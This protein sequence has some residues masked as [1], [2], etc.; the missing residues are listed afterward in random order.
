[1]GLPAAV[2][3][4][5][6]GGYGALQILE[7]MSGHSLTLAEEAYYATH[8]MIFRDVVNTAKTAYAQEAEFFGENSDDDEGD[9][10][11]HCYWSTLL[12]GKI[13]AKDSGFVTSLHEEIDGN[14]PARKEMDLWNNAIGRNQIKWYMSNQYKVVQ[15]LKHLVEGRLKVIRP[16]SAKL[17]RAKEEFA[18]QGQRY[19][20]DA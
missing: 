20:T 5:I 13:G 4:G 10:F 11:R 7:R 8:P 2:I 14:P 19:S 12:T 9:A 18:A 17:A 3:I 16:N 1:M 15:T 6:A